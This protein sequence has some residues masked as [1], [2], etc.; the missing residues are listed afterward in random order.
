[1][2][3]LENQFRWIF[4]QAATG[5]ALVALDGRFV[6]VN[7]SLCEITAY[8]PAELTQRTFQ[9]IVHPEDVAEGLRQARRLL[10][11]KSHHYS[12]ESRCVRKDGKFVWVSLTVSLVRQPD[13][14]PECFVAV[15]EDIS[16]RKEAE[17]VLS[18]YAKR[19]AVLQD[20]DRA[21]L[22]A[23]SL[24]EL[25]PSL[26]PAIAGLA[27]CRA[28]RLMVFDDRTS[29]DPA[30]LAVLSSCR[31]VILGGLT[32]EST[33][34]W[35]FAH[36]WPEWARSLV[37]VPLLA[38]DR[39]VGWLALVCEDEQPPRPDA[40]EFVQKAA[41]DLAVVVQAGRLRA[42]AEHH[43]Q[44][45]E[46]RVAERSAQLRQSRAQLQA[47]N[48]EIAALAYT[49]SHDLQTPLRT[50][51]GFAMAL[52]ED[53]GDRLDD[54]GR[55][56]TKAIIES[57]QRQYLLIQ[58]L[59]EF[60][61]ISRSELRLGSVSLD[62]ALAAARAKRSSEIDGRSARIEVRQPLPR[63]H[64][65]FDTLAQILANLLDNAVKFVAPGVRACV[66]IWAEKA[67]GR[68]RLVVEDNGIGIRQ[69]HQTRIFQVFERLHAERDYAGTGIGL[70][71][72]RK[73]LERMG[74]ACG[75]ESEPG[76]GSRFWI[77]LAASQ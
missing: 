37:R 4:E 76:R 1:M 29:A 8:A 20:L 60:I 32:A 48:E 24:K 53:Y 64:A 30:G 23:R 67:D 25:A 45:L 38:E 35:G 39:L 7:P 5:I 47:L 15:V 66:R 65:Y 11:R 19:L 17:Q 52:S 69:E 63:M 59:V 16:N 49:V 12:L 44:E 28:A 58:G 41:D 54:A 56:Y 9:T 10:A 77:E 26:L 75:V 21:I 57:L 61:Q 18:C 14:E 73:G 13:G 33:P 36:N 31:S 71:I 62:R 50:M 72:V 3:D 55:Q 42:Q 6:R 46:Q 2:D 27:D 70:A 43:V 40:L 68:I 34:H 22:S 74:G 51:H